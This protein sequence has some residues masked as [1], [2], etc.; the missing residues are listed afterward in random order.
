MDVDAFLLKGSMGIIRVHKT[1]IHKESHEDNRRTQ[2]NEIDMR[3]TI[4]MRK[5]KFSNSII[6]NI[7]KTTDN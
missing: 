7:N 3:N 4:N 1:T 6:E 5:E 2:I